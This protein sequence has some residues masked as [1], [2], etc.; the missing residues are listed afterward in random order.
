MKGAR[1]EVRKPADVDAINI[2]FLLFSSLE[3]KH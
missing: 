3:N 2:C 1:H